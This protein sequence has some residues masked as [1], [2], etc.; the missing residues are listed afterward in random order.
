MLHLYVFLIN[1][2][3]LAVSESCWRWSKRSDF[4]YW[5]R[6]WCQHSRPS[7]WGKLWVSTTRC[8]LACIHTADIFKF[9]MAEPH[10]VCHSKVGGRMSAILNSHKKWRIISWSLTCLKGDQFLNFFESLLQ[11]PNI[12]VV[13]V[14]ACFSFHQSTPLHKAAEKGRK[15]VVTYLVK[16]GARVSIKDHDGVSQTFGD[17]I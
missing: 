14:G 3:D 17:T 1:S 15:N 12:F 10:I 6:N 9:C 2:V 8:R 16:K 7:L 4:S 11:L 5:R 13:N